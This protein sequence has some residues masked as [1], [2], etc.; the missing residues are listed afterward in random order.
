[1]SA[2]VCPKRWARLPCSGCKTTKAKLS[3]AERTFRCE[4]CG[5]VID[6]DLNAAA[7]LASLGT[8]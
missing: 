6:R 2:L 4:H 1:M 7:N 3:L 8:A 5:L